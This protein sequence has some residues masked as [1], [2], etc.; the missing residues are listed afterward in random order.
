MQFI[1][2]LNI[3]RFQR[4]LIG[5]VFFLVVV[6]RIYALPLELFLPILGVATAVFA[7]TVLYQPQ[8]YF[9]VFRWG[10]T[11]FVPLSILLLTIILVVSPSAVESFGYEDKQ[12][13]ILSATAV[14]L[15]SIL[16][17]VWGARQAKAGSWFNLA[18]ALAMGLVFM[19]IGLEEISYGQ[20]I[21]DIQSNQFFLEHNMQGE[22]NL[23]NLSTY[24]SEKIFYTAGLLV[25]IVIPYFHKNIKKY[26]EKT[27]L[28][29]LNLFLPSSW[30]WLAFVAIAGL[31][32]PL[33]WTMLM[34]I[35]FAYAFLVKALADNVSKHNWYAAAPYLGLMLLMVV[36]RMAFEY[37]PYGDW[38]VIVPWRWSE[39]FE[40]YIQLGLLVY[41]IDFMVRNSPVLKRKY[42][43]GLK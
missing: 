9:K 35:I 32:A 29:P 31:S 4:W 30:M 14:I 3:N 40:F 19:M 16:W 39:Y 37:Y 13:E 33:N 42:A 24:L 11:L 38:S 26:L 2:D 17:F 36:T 43:K 1:K 28:K 6:R 27:K 8:Q 20:R 21:F 23:H 22:T 25:L 7:M 15:A 18:I 12:V 34:I 10:I 41:T 5:V